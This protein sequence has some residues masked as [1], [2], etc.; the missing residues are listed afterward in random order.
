MALPQLVVFVESSLRA[1]Q[2]RDA[3]RAALE[4]AGWS[5][6]QIADA[7]AHFADLA[8]AVPVPRPRAQLSARDAF[9]YLLMFATLYWSAFYLADLLFGFINRAYPDQA[10]LS[11]YGDNTEYVE[12][13]IRWATAALIVAFPVFIFAAL[14]IGR[15]VAADP[16][17]RNSAMRKWLTYL[18]LLL[19]ASAIVGDGVTLVYNMLSGELTVR[20][21][22]KVVVVA[23]I[24]AAVF[25]YYTW[26]MRRDDEALGR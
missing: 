24:A 25:G 17:R 12:R 21:I 10:N 14:K 1:G 19:A 6:D 4:Q 18:T 22:L 20:F 11:Y 8:F 23:V 13:G 9:W 15:E 26:S 2:S 5:K 3:V 16:T 7:L